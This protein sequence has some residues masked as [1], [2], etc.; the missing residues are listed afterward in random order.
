[1]TAK[2]VDYAYDIFISYSSF[3]K[4]GG[5]SQFDRKVAER[6]HKALETY[7]VPSSLVKN[8]SNGRRLPPRLKKVFRDRDEVRAGASLNE[9]LRDA[10]EKSRF[11]VVICSP[12]A[13]N[14]QWMNQEI[15]LFRS[16]G[17]ENRILPILIEGEPPEVF[18]RELL[19]SKPKNGAAE[20]TATV[21]EGLL[22]QPLAADIRA[23]T[24]S[25][26]LYLL[27]QEKLRLIATV[28]DCDYDDLRRREHERFVRRTTTIVVA[29]LAL[30]VILT[31]LSVGLFLTQQR[32][33]RNAQL[34]LDATGVIPM[35]AFPEE[36]RELDN[37][38]GREIRL[39]TSIN[40][41]E[42]LRQDYPENVQ[43][44]EGLRH[45]YAS[46][47]HVLKVQGRDEDAHAAYD[48]GKALVVPI[49]I[50]RLKA[51]R[52]NASTNLQGALLE[53]ELKRWRDLLK[54]WED[55]YDSTRAKDAVEYVDN[56]T[57]YLPLLDA[58]TNE[59]IDEA[60]RVLEWSLKLFRKAK[61][62]ETLT[63]EQEELVETITATLSELPQ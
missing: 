26:S 33:K 2:Q 13:R 7:R 54:V 24:E 52:P 6:L 38:I 14:S 23:E 27:K 47:G 5:E 3:R 40:N 57:E 43:C 29:M 41:L 30:I 11:L 49:A 37:A 56:A 45:I 62:R 4:A 50:S 51:W 19:K 55:Y 44:L 35:I 46:L 60:R 20:S 63:A 36:S 12:R 31:S 48:K 59:G 10:L 61:E 34:A 39:T 22:A 21:P 58:S 9:A 28:L 53:S 15:A 42:T 18:P 16:L 25:E 8:N 17:R 1:M 32:E